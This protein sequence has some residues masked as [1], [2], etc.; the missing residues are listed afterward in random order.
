LADLNSILAE[1]QSKQHKGQGETLAAQDTVRRRYLKKLHEFTGRNVIAYYSGFLSKPNVADTGITD[2]DKNGL[3]MAVHKL[4][5]KEGLD[6]LLHTPG[7]S[8]AVTESMVDYLK[9][10]FGRDIRAIVPQIAMSA[11]TM[12]ACACREIVMG[13]HSSLGP[14]DPQMNGIPAA[15]VIEEFKRA[16]AEIVKDNTRLAVWQFILSKYPPSY[17]GRC[18]NAVNWAR[19]FARRSLEENMLAAEPKRKDLAQ[20]IVNYLTDFTNNRAHDRHIPIEECRRI[21]LRVRPLEQDPQ[22]QDRVLSVHHCYM[23]ALA[24]TPA[25]KIIENHLGAAYVKTQMLATPVGAT[26]PVGSAMSLP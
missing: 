8:I 2:E 9:T 3:M 14:I 21:G 26:T 11:G 17:L 5:R 6:L 25:T 19:E 22:M 15:G 1:I 4:A 12:I 23:H 7:G 13:T 24:N 10:M 18:E 20:A 16:H